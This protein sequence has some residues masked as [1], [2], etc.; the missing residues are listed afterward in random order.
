MIVNAGMKCLRP[1][2]I[3]AL[4]IIFCISDGAR[5][6]LSALCLG[7]G[8]RKRINPPTQFPR[9]LRDIMCLSPAVSLII[10]PFPMENWDWWISMGYW[11]IPVGLLE[12]GK[13]VTI[14]PTQF[15]M[16]GLYFTAGHETTQRR[17]RTLVE[18]C[19]NQALWP[20][21]LRFRCSAGALKSE[22]AKTKIGFSLK[23]LGWLFSVE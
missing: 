10:K 16:E 21:W 12:R 2:C 22:F 13:W 3:H 6:K 11:S 14:S 8:S 20:L 17:R 1:L 15:L 7:C 18:L 5:L 23:H 4:L 19:L 9:S